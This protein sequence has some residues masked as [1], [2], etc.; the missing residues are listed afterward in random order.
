[1]GLLDKARSA[2]TITWTNR[3]TCPPGYEFNDDGWVETQVATPKITVSLL[4]HLI[5]KIG[6][7]QMIFQNLLALRL[8]N[9]VDAPILIDALWNR[10]TQAMLGRQPN[11]KIF[12]DAVQA[13]MEIESA[14]NLPEF[15]EDIVRMDTIWFSKTCREKGRAAIKQR[16]RNRYISDVRSFMPVRTKY[17]T[18]EVML[19]AEVSKYAVNL[20]WKDQY[21]GA[22]A[23]ALAAVTEA[24]TDL[25]N[26]NENVTLSV[27]AQRAGISTRSLQRYSKQ[28]ELT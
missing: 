14:D 22:S 18:K 8:L 5:N 13:A 28:L 27:L 10:A 2:H 16:I 24:Y 1:M 26:N 15:V 3:Y 7:Y 11:K 19:E 23:R 12:D 9:T 4:P 25:L 17:K 6:E 20:Y 21:L